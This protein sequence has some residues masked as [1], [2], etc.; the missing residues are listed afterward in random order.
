[1]TGRLLTEHISS[2]GRSCRPTVAAAEKQGHSFPGGG[3]LVG[4]VS[5]FHLIAGLFAWS[6]LFADLPFRLPLSGRPTDNLYRTYITRGSSWWLAGWHAWGYR[7]RD[8]KTGVGGGGVEVGGE[9]LHFPTPNGRY[10]IR[11]LV[12]LS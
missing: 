9:K 7:L 8:G 1:M 12:G 2:S 6:C 4:F 5:V 10:I 11:L 3:N